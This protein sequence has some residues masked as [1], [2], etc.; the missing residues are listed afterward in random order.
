MNQFPEYLLQVGQHLEAAGTSWCLIGGLAVGARTDPRF[1]KDLDLAVNSQNDEASEQLLF[2]LQGAGYR[3][4]AILEH[5]A[6][7]RLATARLAPPGAQEPVI[8]DLLFASSGIE[9]SIVSRSEVLEVF[10]EVRVPVASLGDLIAMKI[11]ARDDKI[12][13]QD[14]LDLNALLN[15]AQEHDRKIARKALAEMA[16]RGYN[17]GR[18]L[19]AEL[20]AAEAEFLTE[21]P[22]RSDTESDVGAEE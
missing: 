5:Q 12:R 18:Q 17:R 9:G 22:G 10:H 4:L 7:G 13:P 16:E 14:R 6:S 11:L 3:I 20:T 8:I 1:T 21:S 15:L 19:E 2:A